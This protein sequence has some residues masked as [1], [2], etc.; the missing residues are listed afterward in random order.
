MLCLLE[1]AEVIVR[2]HLSVQSMQTYNQGTDIHSCIT[3]EI[4]RT[5]SVLCCWETIAH[6]IPHSYEQ[7]SIELLK[8]VISLWV[9]VRAYA[10][11]K[12]WT[13]KFEKKY[14]KGTRKSLQPQR[15]ED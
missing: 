8:A 1:E 7:Y 13:M 15:V 10:F 5:N 4:M 11:A 3:D 12:G 6:S 9:T 2:R 14:K